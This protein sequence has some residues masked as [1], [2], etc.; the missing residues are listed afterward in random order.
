V[1]RANWTAGF[2]ALAEHSASNGYRPGPAPFETK[3]GKIVGTVRKS[4]L[5][6][7]RVS[8]VMMGDV[9]CI[10]IRAW[11]APA[12]GKGEWV[13]RSGIAVRLD[14]CTAVADLL[15]RAIV[16]AEADGRLQLPDNGDDQ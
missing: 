7:I 1:S 10:N 13:P 8:F 2:A 15:D 16:E 3:P 9:E 11:D 5:S 12:G 4:K 14:L 6:E